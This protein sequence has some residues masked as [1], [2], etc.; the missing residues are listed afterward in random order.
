MTEKKIVNKKEFID[1][2]SESTNFSKK[3]LLTIV[4]AEQE[5]LAKILGNGDSFKL[6]GFGMFE[7]RE[8]AARKGRNPQTGEEI[9]IPESRIVAFKPGKKL[10]D[11]LKQ[12]KL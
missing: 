4:D 8:R 7:V 10:K 6:I 5:L 2:L 1:A 11:V 3:D 12:P 9:E